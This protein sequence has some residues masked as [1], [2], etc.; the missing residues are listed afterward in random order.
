M[1]TLLFTMTL[2]C[3]NFISFSQEK[4]ELDAKSLEETIYSNRINHLD[5]YY[6]IESNFIFGLEGNSINNDKLISQLNQNKSIIK[7]YF[8]EKTN[9][10]IVITNKTKENDIVNFIKNAIYSNGFNINTFTETI[11]KK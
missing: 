4:T 9:N 6:N 5:K 3:I 10:L 8:E 11:Y 2:M 7:S 1:K